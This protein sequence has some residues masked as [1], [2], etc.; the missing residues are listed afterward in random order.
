VQSIV[1]RNVD[2]L[3]TAVVS[4]TSIHGGTTFNVIPPMVEMTGT[5]RTFL[6]EVREVVVKRMEE[7]VHS[8]AEGMGCTAEIVIDD[9][10]PA[11]VND[12]NLAELVKETIGEVL[13]EVHY[14]PSLMT[15]GSED[16][17]FLMRDVPGCFIFV[18]SNNEYKGLVYGHHHPKFDIDEE[19]LLNGVTLITASAVKILNGD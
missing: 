12:E 8:V 9:I 17:A 15:M 19:S 18:G 16:M 4:I 11:V 14:L 10:S 6:P 13:P 7:L 3:G 5:I 2:P 1:A